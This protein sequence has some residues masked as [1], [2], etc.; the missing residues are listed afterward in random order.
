LARAIERVQFRAETLSAFRR[1]E[2][3]LKVALAAWDGLDCARALA[4]VAP[5]LSLALVPKA[6]ESARELNTEDFRAGALA[7]L[8]ARP[9]ELPWAQLLS[10]WKDTLRFLGTHSRTG[11]LVGLSAL[12]PVILLLR[13][14]NAMEAAHRAN[15]QPRP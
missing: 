6:L 3:A 7:A 10:L 15:N 1:V 13:G 9:V 5:H 4:A 11:L 12:A 8:A 14:P 2:E